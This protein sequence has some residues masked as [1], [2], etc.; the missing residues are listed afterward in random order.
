MIGSNQKKKIWLSEYEG[1]RT[2]RCALQE[3]K[4]GNIEI[5]FER[6]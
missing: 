5:R 2:E 4:E 1:L 3:R 6:E